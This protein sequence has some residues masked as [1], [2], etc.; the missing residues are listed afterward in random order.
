MT[1]KIGDFGL[2]REYT[3][4][5]A[6]TLST[7][8]VTLWY[9]PPELLMGTKR[10]GTKVDIWSAGCIISEMARNGEVLFKGRGEWEVL[11]AILRFMGTPSRRDSWCA[12]L[13]YFSVHFP[14]FKGYPLQ[15]ALGRFAD[16]PAACDLLQKM[17]QLDSTKRWNAIC[18]LKHQW[19]ESVV[20]E[21]KYKQLH[22][23]DLE[24]DI[25]SD[26][27]IPSSS[28][29]TLSKAVTVRTSTT[30]STGT[31]MEAVDVDC[32][33]ECEPD[34][35]QSEQSCVFIHSLHLIGC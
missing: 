29:S 15:R 20:K 12:D 11:M 14:K 30:T 13:P 6:S 25:R 28:F 33:S 31:V 22:N 9:R 5:I 10:Y 1:I 21:R 32:K 35:G 16:N 7:Q 23:G 4:P 19:F 3:V 17:V 26:A 27:S 8:I 2:G 34:E 24:S 18:L